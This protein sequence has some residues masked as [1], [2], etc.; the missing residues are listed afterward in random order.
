MAP[1]ITLT[2]ELTNQPIVIEVD[3]VWFVD[4][5]PSGKGSVLTVA[6]VKIAVKEELIDVNIM[7]VGH[8]A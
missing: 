1:T 7:L 4:K 6:G 8:G 5:Q 2:R 3:K